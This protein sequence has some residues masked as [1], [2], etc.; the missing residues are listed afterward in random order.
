[1]VHCPECK[2]ELTCP[3]PSCKDRQPEVKKWLWLDGETPTC[4]D[5]G[6]YVEELVD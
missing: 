6:A 4:P 5:C 2:I 1:M 3:C